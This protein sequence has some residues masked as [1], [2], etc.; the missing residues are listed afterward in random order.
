MEGFADETFSAELWE[1]AVHQI[2]RVVAKYPTVEADELAAELAVALLEIRRRRAP[3]RVIDWKAYL[4]KCLLNSAS[5]FA[6]RYRRIRSAE[7]TTDEDVPSP[8][9]P[10]QVDLRAIYRSLDNDDRHLVKQLRESRWNVSH[11]AR[12][13]RLP[14]N[15]IH[16]RLRRIRSRC[17]VEIESAPFLADPLTE[18][19]LAQLASIIESPTASDRKRLRARVIQTLL[20]RRPYAEIAT[21]FGTSSS[22]IARWRRRF[23]SKGI[24][25]LAAA[26]RG[27][28]P[29]QAA[30][31]IRSWLET[32]PASERPSIREI[33]RRFGLRKS[34]VH[35]ILKT[36][37][38]GAVSRSTNPMESGGKP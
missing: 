27:R 32:T 16:R 34:A 25:G 37:G 35:D 7:T 30:A 23:D 13:L 4:F 11:A 38:D 36:V 8:E 33:G 31:R 12:K 21:R 14:R 29:S 3:R 22:T 24:A 19:L 20:H 17:P 18:S 26:H 5:R 28:K 10:P 9:R 2:P 6:R 1:W 15:T